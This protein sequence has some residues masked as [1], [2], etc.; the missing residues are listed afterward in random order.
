MILNHSYRIFTHSPLERYTNVYL[1]FAPSNHLPAI[2]SVRIDNYSEH[3]GLRYFSV[4]VVGTI[5]EALRLK[6]FNENENEL[7]LLLRHLLFSS[8]Y[9]FKCHFLRTEKSYTLEMKV[10]NKHPGNF[11]KWLEKT[12]FALNTHCYWFSSATYISKT[13]VTVFVLCLKMICLCCKTHYN[14][15]QKA[16]QNDKFINSDN[17]IKNISAFTEI[18][19]LCYTTFALQQK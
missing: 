4:Q 12:V 3:N 19:K 16:Q 9:H 14:F 13:N 18:T 11:F 10:L 17:I 2:V 1:F 6:F 8:I 5:P 15:N 7:L